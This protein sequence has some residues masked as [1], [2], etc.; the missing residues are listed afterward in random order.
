MKL[1]LSF[2]LLGLLLS[3]QTAVASV[4]GKDPV[5]DVSCNFKTG[6]ATGTGS[7]T[8]VSPLPTCDGTTDDTASFNAF[9]TWAIGTWQASHSGLIELYISPGSCSLTTA[10]I[11]FNGIKKLRVSAYAVTLNGTYYHLAGGGQKQDADHSTRLLT[12]AAG[13]SAVTVNPAS[14]SQPS[15]CN[16]NATCTALFSVGGWALVAGFDLQSGI[17]F[18]S[19]PAYFQYVRITG[20]NSSTGVITFD[21]PLTTTYKSTWPN[22]NKGNTPMAV[23]DDGGPATLYVFDPGWDTEVEWRGITFTSNTQLDAA[24]RSAIFR[25]TVWTQAGI[26]KCLAPSQNRSIQLINATMS[27]CTMEFDK[28]V[29]SATFSNVTISQFTFQSRG[30]NVA[31]D[32]SIVGNFVG[33]PANLTITNSSVTGQLLAGTSGYGRSDTLT[34]S[35]T[36]VGSLGDPAFHVGKGVSY[37]GSMMP[38]EGFNNIAGSSMTAG[39]VTLPTS[40]IAAHDGASGWMQPDT[41]VCWSYDNT[42]CAG[43]IFQITDVTQDATNTYVAM[44]APGGTYPTAWTGSGVLILQNVPVPVVRFSSVS[45]DPDAVA[46]NNAAAQGLPLYAYNARTYVNADTG[47]A[48]PYYPIWGNLK[49]LN[50]TVNTAYTGSLTSTMTPNSLFGNWF[51][52]AAAI[53][54]YTPAIIN[55]KVA[56]ARALD[57]TGGYPATWSGAQSGDT[58]TTLSASRFSPTLFR[59]VS[60]DI[61]SDPSHPMSVT[62]EVITDMGLVIP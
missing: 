53:V 31:V 61:S 16:S 6:V 22:Y 1:L 20:I 27:V 11:T 43:P 51:T 33:T 10:A 38:A 37:G 29:E 46:L 55:L 28:M 52:S 3:F 32:R 49:K 25:D 24:G 21:A 62:V 36:S 50:V 9:A 8:C 56:G 44:N 13:N 59:S 19:N 17:G 12:V 5:P 40:Y 57:A 41:N 58:L 18:P 23:P 39:V 14:S 26:Q 47:N 34:V 4:H 60:N 7:G 48:Q 2:A 35:S 45:G 15:A 30:K 54:A 42:S